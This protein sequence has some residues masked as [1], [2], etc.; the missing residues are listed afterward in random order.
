[1]Y[2]QELLQK[3][4]EFA[5]QMAECDCTHTQTLGV[6]QSRNLV[7]QT[8][9]VL[10][11]SLKC[12]ADMSICALP[13]AV[14]VSVLVAPLFCWN[15]NTRLSERERERGRTRDR[16]TDLA[17]SRQLSTRRTGSSAGAEHFSFFQFVVLRILFF[18]GVCSFE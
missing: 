3:K 10:A 5:C 14:S 6:I 7:Q 12:S 11:R 16:G 9:V 2:S 18:F 13:S 4:A 15:F 1:M 8:F 17:T